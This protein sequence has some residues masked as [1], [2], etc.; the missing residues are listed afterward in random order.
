MNGGYPS[1]SLAIPPTAETLMAESFCVYKW[2]A[3][4]LKMFYS[5]DIKQINKCNEMELTLYYSGPNP[6]TPAP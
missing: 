5:R 3:S 1:L 4:Q 2:F 6:I